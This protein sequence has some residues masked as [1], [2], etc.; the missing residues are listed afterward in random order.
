MGLILAIKN[1]E[2]AL[3]QDNRVLKKNKQPFSTDYYPELDDT[4]L[5]NDEETNY[6]QSQV[7]ILRWMIELGRLDI[8]VHVALLSSYLVQ[9]RRGHLEAIYNI[10]GYLKQHNCSTMVFDDAPIEW[11]RHGLPQE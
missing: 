5:L 6:Y 10:Y 3:A 9:P 8:Y 4:A 7:S 11:K 1:I 2:Q